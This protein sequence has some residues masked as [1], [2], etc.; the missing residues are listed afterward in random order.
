MKKGFIKKALK[1]LTVLSL[2]AAMTLTCFTG[3]G[4]KK[5]DEP[6]T[7]T[8]FSMRANYNG[9][10]TGWSGKVFLDQFNVVL[11]IVPS[12]NGAFDTR[13]EAGNLGDI[14]VLGE[15]Q[16][17]QAKDAGLLFDWEEDDILDEYGSYI[18]DNMTHALEKCRNM[19][20][21][22][23]YGVG[24]QVAT[25][26]SDIQS[27]FY[28]WDIRWD[29]YKQLGYPEVKD[30]D[31]LVDVFVAMKEICPKDDAGKE[32]YAV[33]LWPDWDGDMVMYVKST[34]TAYYGYEGDM[35]LGH[36][37]PENGEFYGCLDE[38][39]PYLEMLK[40]YNKLYQNDLVDPDSM[41]ATYD[42]M[43]EKV[44]NGGTFFSIFN[45][46]GYL[47]YNTDAHASEG[48]MMMSLCPEEARPIV[49]GQSVLGGNTY[50]AIGSKSEYP[51]LCMEIINWMATPEGML[52][53]QYGPQGVT[54]DYDEEGNT[55]FTELGKKT[56]TDNQTPM[57]EEY[58]G[59]YHD[60]EL[61]I[62]CLTWMLDAS[63]PNSNGETYNSK[64]WKSEQ[65]EA[66]YE[67]EADW[68]EFTG[69][70]SINQY[71][72]KTDYVVMPGSDYVASVKSDELKATWSQ[73]TTEITTGS[74][75]AIYAKT[76]EEF[77]QIVD[78]M[79]KNA[80]GFGYQECLEWSKNEAAIR[81][82]REQA[83]AD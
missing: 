42:T 81:Y 62:N 73:V 1:R 67:I 48:K 26:S 2:T 72:L 70:N 9:E 82:A 79:I 60:G 23:L 78:Q 52:T 33:S 80:N 76:D 28:T 7:I 74:W 17:L 32:T 5:G 19:T 58:G 57:P 65:A 77:D 14:L 66:Q 24:Y 54:W 43:I 50:W 6:I 15:E 64:E 29:L 71:M 36:Y 31:D 30:L 68:R 40:F 11:N 46:A 13:M 25:S 75:K 12:T 56:S 44:K 59:T 35:G 38:G 4:K 3:C 8:V 69:A 49:Y 27:F 83:L 51:E 18:R 55:Y 16:F 37:N 10:Q 39:S 53:V 22:K 47:A 63:N 41:T 45:Y 61:Q 21:G 34:A 20:D